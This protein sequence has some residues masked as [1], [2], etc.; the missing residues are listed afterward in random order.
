MRE[1]IDASEVRRLRTK[2]ALRIAA[3]SGVPIAVGAT[4]AFAVHAWKSRPIEFEPGPVELWVVDRDGGALIGLDSE[5][6]VARRAAIPSP[7]EVE[8]RPGGG[9]WVASALDGS[10]R[11]RHELIAFDAEL[12]IEAR[13]A[14]DR[15]LD[16]A[17]LDDDA[18]AVEISDDDRTSV[19]RASRDGAVR[20]LASIDSAFAI[21]AR[22]DRMLVGT[23]RGDV[24]LFALDGGTRTLAKRAL[25]GA[26]GDLAPG[27]DAKSWWA[28]DTRSGGRLWLVDD[29]LAPRWSAPLG[30]HAK[31]FAPIAGREQVWIAAAEDSLVRRYGAGGELETSRTPLALAGVDRAT[32]LRDGGCALVAPGAVLR[33]DANGESLP[34][35]GG[36]DFLVD[37]ARVAP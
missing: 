24:E 13:I 30:M 36:F 20:E 7:I 37:V 1:Q 33:I 15:V 6:F 21:A 10:P 28:L 9:A 8:A 12:R 2:R 14:S 25:G 16:L 23:A 22:D 17:I 34:G 31:H 5:L 4:A 27:P 11:G 3:A 35:Q 18:L 32:A 26:I 29:E 19:R